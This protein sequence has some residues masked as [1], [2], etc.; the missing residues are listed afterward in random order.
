MKVFISSPCYDLCDLRAELSEDLRDLG[1]EPVLSNDP[2]S[3]FR[4]PIEPDINSIE[5][6][7]V[8]LRASD[9][10]IVVLSQRYGPA[11]PPPFEQVSAT[12]LEYREAVRLKKKIG[13]YTRTDLEAE[14]CVWRKTR[15]KS[16]GQIS[17]AFVSESDA[18]GLFSLIEEHRK[19][20]DPDGTVERNNFFTTY[21]TSVDL[22]A[23]IRR[24]IEPEA[25]LAIGQKLIDKGE[26]PILL[27]ERQ[28]ARPLEGGVPPVSGC[29][30]HFSLVNA[31]PVAAIGVCPVLVMEGVAELAATKLTTVLPHKYATTDTVFMVSQPMIAEA[32]QKANGQPFVARL[33]AGYSIPTG[34]IMED[35]SFIHL[36]V[37]NDELHLIA[38]PDHFNKRPCGMRRFGRKRGGFESV[39]RS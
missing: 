18:G 39:V 35:E 2:E 9:L 15:R 37:K 5:A 7:L 6:C 17:P 33:R 26:V 36:C 3:G 24:A 31:G 13:F 16:G 8:N 20:V 11:L 32:S 21:R 30:L 4:V 19:L 27:V 10:V 38:A 1:V 34:H 22:R 29:S 14:F 12:H 23:T 28:N 25:S